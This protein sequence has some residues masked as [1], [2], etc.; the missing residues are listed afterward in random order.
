MHEEKLCLFPPHVNESFRK[1][2]VAAKAVLEHHFNNHTF[3]GK[4]CPA[5]KWKDDERKKKALK[6]RCKVK[7][8]LLYEQMKAIHNTYTDVWWNLQEIYHEFHS[9][10][11]ESLNGFRTKFL[12]EHKHKHY[13]WSIINRARTYLAVRKV[14]FCTMDYIGYHNHSAD[15][16]APST[17][18]QETPLEAKVWPVR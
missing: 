8:A 7:H 12:L 4:W 13:C 6:Y 16:W 15:H 10:K 2:K 11:C 14:L 18:G 5:N 17:V 1:F 9:N 3:C